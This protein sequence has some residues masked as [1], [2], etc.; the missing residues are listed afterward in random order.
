MFKYPLAF[1]A[2]IVVFSSC[3]NTPKESPPPCDFQSILPSGNDVDCGYITVP[4]NHDQP[5]GKKI[6]IAFVVLHSKD[7]NT[8]E[9]PVI[10]LSGGPGGSS[11]DNESVQR[12]YGHPFREKQD[13]I[14]LDQRGIGYSSALPNIYIEL[15]GIMAKDANQEQ[16]QQMMDSLMTA[17]SQKCKDNG[18]ELQYYN[19]FQNAR[20]VGALMDNLGYEKYNLYGVSYGTRLARVTQDIFPDKLNSVILNSPNPIKGDMLVDRLKSYALALSRV[21]DYCNNN[22]ECHAAYPKL[23]EDYFKAINGLAEKPLEL[24]INGDDVYINAQDGIF[25]VRRLLY[26]NNSRRDIPLLI[27]EYLN[28]GGPIITK[29]A[30]EE[31]APDYNFAMWFAVERHEMYDPANTQPVVDQVYD[32][33][34]LLPYRLGLFNAA[35]MNLGRLHDSGASAEQ[36]KFKPS[37]IPTLITV[38]QF[39]PVTPPENGKIMME[40]L[41]NGHLFILDEGGHGGGDVNCRNKVMISFMNNPTGELDASCLNVY[42][43]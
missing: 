25:F 3:Q 18:I 13:I 28:G 31:Y 33:L 17:Y 21:I 4:E 37:S 32:S 11:L 19:T 23:Q 16:E 8:K 7:P 15:N 26:G 9:Y 10:Y 41:S 5:D 36:K 29:L 42:K 22:A 24:V 39:D 12:W 30:S 40:T 2:L 1:I 43:E 14:L 6:N 27:Q 35:Y 20:D 34:A 38:N